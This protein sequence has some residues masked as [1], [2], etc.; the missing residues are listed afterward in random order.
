MFASVILDFSPS[1]SVL[2]T[3]IRLE[4]LALAGIVFLAIVWTGLRA[5]RSRLR[6][7]DGSEV[8]GAPRLRRDD[9]ILIAFGAVPGAVVGA[10]IGYGV[11]HFDYYGSLLDPGKGGFELT[12]AVLL[13]TLTA[14]SVARL[15]AAPIGRWLAVATVPVFLGLGLGKL[16]MVLGG[17]GQGAYSD[18]A[19]ATSYAGAGPWNSANP[20]FPAVPSQAIEGG[21]VVALVAA[22]L[23]VPFIFR[24]RLV[25]WGFLVR[26]AL[27]PRRE[28]ALLSGRRRYMTVLAL[29][30]IVRFGVAFSWRDA[31]VLGPFGAEQLILIPAIATL[32]AG[33]TA[34]S[35][36]RR[37]RVG[38]S[39]WRLARRERRALAAEAKA[40]AA[41]QA[42]EAA[43][44]AEAAR[45]AAEAKAAAEAE[46]AEAARVA[47]EEAKAAEDAEAA[48]IA[49]AARVAAAA[50]AAEEAKAAEDAEAAKIAEAARVAAESEA[51]EEAEAADEA[52][53][54]EAREVTDAPDA[55]P[56]G[57]LVAQGAA[58]T[59]EPDEVE[60]LD[61]AKGTFAW[62]RPYGQEAAE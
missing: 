7:A 17:A 30:A 18:A 59:D 37:A 22:I 19:Y 26:P 35:A 10:R 54:A 15:L 56:R 61:Q 8:E 21:L 36:W 32:L 47:A 14:V 53:A 16:A 24:L 49:E 55:P 20:D 46:V 51:A 1:T 34:L 2:G 23:I 57:T 52:S 33:P 38:V 50:K 60:K 11:I 9:L 40:A 42:A 48:K 5:G 3:T 62:H 58:T 12:L 41:A 29:W 25:S 43:K 45:V 28:W 44:I 4:T 13:G 31:R 6:H 27:A 39:A